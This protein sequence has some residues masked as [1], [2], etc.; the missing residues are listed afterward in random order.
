MEKK[1][2]VGGSFLLN[3]RGSLVE[4]SRE[5]IKQVHGANGNHGSIGQDENDL[6]CNSYSNGSGCDYNWTHDY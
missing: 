2:E 1:S 6:A 4:L 3:A 5:E